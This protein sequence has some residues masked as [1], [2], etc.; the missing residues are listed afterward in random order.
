M[1]CPDLRMQ[2]VSSLAPNSSWMM[3][4]VLVYGVSFIG[5]PTEIQVE[6]E[7]FTSSAEIFCP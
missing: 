3:S 5:E 4:T 6:F 2:D 7:T 1:Y